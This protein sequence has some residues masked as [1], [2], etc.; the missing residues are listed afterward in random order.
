MPRPHIDDPENPG[1]VCRWL[2]EFI[3]N[4]TG[5]TRFYWFRS[6]SLK[7]I[8]RRFYNGTIPN[9]H[10]IA[11]PEWRAERISPPYPKKPRE[12]VKWYKVDGRIETCKRWHRQKRAKQWA[13]RR[14]R[15]SHYKRRITRTRHNLDRTWLMWNGKKLCSMYERAILVARGQWKDFLAGDKSVLNNLRAERPRHG[16]K[17]KDPI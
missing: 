15:Q 16:V 10:N 9:P 4:E 14:A 11:P 8:L 17:K 5:K 3:H 2:V 1:F 7:Y 13:K 6:K 12:V